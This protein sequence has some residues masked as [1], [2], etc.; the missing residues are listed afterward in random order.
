MLEYT[1]D[2]V[3][4]LPRVAVWEGRENARTKSSRHF[5]SVTFPASLREEV[6]A[7]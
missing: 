4:D 2:V 7:G 3:S 1:M 6:R 5:N